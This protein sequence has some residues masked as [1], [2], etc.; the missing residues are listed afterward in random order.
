VHNFQSSKKI[1]PLANSTVTAARCPTSLCFTN[2]SSEI[3][4]CEAPQ[5]VSPKRNRNHHGDSKEGDE[6]PSAASADNE[7]RNID[8][9]SQRR[10]SNGKSDDDPR[11]ASPTV[12]FISTND[13]I[14]SK[15]FCASDADVGFMSINFRRRIAGLTDDYAGNY[16]GFIGYQR[17]DY[18]SPALIRKSLSNF[19]RANSSGALYP[20]FFARCEQDL[21]DFKLVDFLRRL[22]DGWMYANATHAVCEST[23]STDDSWNHLYARKKSTGADDNGVEFT[24][25]CSHDARRGAFGGFF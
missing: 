8:Y 16:E 13:L 17:G 12:G 6:I 20:G 18:E 3:D 2:L 23:S 9:Q 19:H 10:G 24:G 25:A 21:H 15:F 11:I 7:C 1:K 14:T 22:G 4:T 5:D